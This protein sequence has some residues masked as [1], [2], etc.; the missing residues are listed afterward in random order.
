M[1]ID[2]P[3]KKRKKKLQKL[4]R[5]ACPRTEQSEW[6]GPSIC[7]YITCN[8]IIPI[9]NTS[10]V[11]CYVLNSTNHYNSTPSL[12]YCTVP[13]KNT[14]NSKTH[15]IKQNKI[16]VIAI[17]YLL[18]RMSSTVQV[19]IYISDHFRNVVFVDK[20]RFKVTILNILFIW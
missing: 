16:T 14:S 1:K 11:L 20:P 13:S 18:L 17:V 10:C 9:E 3:Q 7:K 5:G 15:T 6:Y 4:H 12:N 8:C 2:K 19:Q